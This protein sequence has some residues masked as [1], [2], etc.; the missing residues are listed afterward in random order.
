MGGFGFSGFGSFQRVS[1]GFLAGSDGYKLFSDHLRS[2]LHPFKTVRFRTIWDSFWIVI[3]RFF[4]T[5]KKSNLNLTSGQRWGTTW[6]VCPPS[7]LALEPSNWNLTM[8]LLKRKQEKKETKTNGKKSKMTE[9]S[10]RAGVLTARSPQ[11][12][13]YKQAFLD[14]PGLVIHSLRVSHWGPQASFGSF[15]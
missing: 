2:S 9:A 7:R 5:P 4:S 13:A 12:C 6:A 8:C 10:L 14:P 1:D 15:F 3:R 11:G